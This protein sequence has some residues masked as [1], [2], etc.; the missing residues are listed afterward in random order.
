VTV[1]YGG[2]QTFT[3]TPDTCY[4]MADVLVDGASVSAVTSYTFSNVTA[5]HTISSSFAINN[6]III[7]TAGANGSIVPPGPGTVNC[8]DNGT[9]II[10]PNIDY[11]IADVLVDGASVG[12]VGTYTFS[13]VTSHHTISASFAVN[14]YTL[15]ASKTGS[16]TGTVT[17]SP[18]GI[19]Y[20]ADCSEVYN[21]GTPATL[22]ATASA[23]SVFA[24]WS[25]GGCSGTG[26]CPLILEADTSVTATFTRAITVTS[27]NGGESLIRGNTYTINWTYAGVGSSVKIELL[28]GGTLNRTITASTSIGSNGSGSYNWNIPHGQTPGTDYQI[29]ITSTTNGS[30]TD[31]SNGTFA[32]SK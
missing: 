6:Y 13:N 23:D 18:A 5:N 7:A 12:A 11:H 9:Y 14:L 24:G 21:Y 32:I 10:T 2:N 22:T 3:I 30:Y 28:K 4:H 15:T 26:P 29:R 20:G 25:G 31:T 27:P 1:N 16:G 17:S 8:G 19:S